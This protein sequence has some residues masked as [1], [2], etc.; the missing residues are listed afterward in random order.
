MKLFPG[1]MM[2][3]SVANRRWMK[4]ENTA[5]KAMGV[6]ASVVTR[7]GRAPSKAEAAWEDEGGA[8]RRPKSGR[9]FT[10]VRG[11]RPR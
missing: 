10:R 6:L 3:D 7:L 9:R 1:G 11:R 2:H 5:A 4:Q 8:L